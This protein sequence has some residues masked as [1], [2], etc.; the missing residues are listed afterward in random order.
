HEPVVHRDHQA[1]PGTDVDRAMGELGDLPGP[2]TRRVD[3]NSGVNFKSLAVALAADVR[4]HDPLAFDLEV[5]NTVIRKDT[6]PVLL[7]RAGATPDELPRV[8][9]GVRNEE[10]APDVGV[11]AGL[12]TQR[13]RNGDLLSRDAGR[14]AA[15]EEQ[16]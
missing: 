16:V 4:S 1:H 11:D 8:E 13:L 3:D 2:G 7:R 6:R 5:E 14:L 12:A 10:R 9:R 15:L